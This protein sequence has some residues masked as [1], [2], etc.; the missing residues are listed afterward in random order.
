MDAD[1]QL[2]R[3]WVGA[4]LEPGDPASRE[5]L[6]DTRNTDADNE[7]AEVARFDADVAAERLA[8]EDR[9]ALTRGQAI[10]RTH[11]YAEAILKLREKETALLDAL[12]VA[13]S[14]R[15]GKQ[16]LDAIDD[17]ARQ[18]GALE[19]QAF[20]I[21]RRLR[22]DD[23]DITRIAVRNVTVDRRRERE[24]I[25]HARFCARTT[26]ADLRDGARTRERLLRS[27]LRCDGLIAKGARLENAD[28]ALI[29]EL[30]LQLRSNAG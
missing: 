26:N 17:I 21:E 23:A 5:S 1:S 15:V 16:I 18:L 22:K 3:D 8:L 11:R 30:G 20:A 19:K 13:E 7:V 28:P 24:G 6:G 12:L 10:A 9:A 14:V 4:G 29:A 25:R 2:T 27:A